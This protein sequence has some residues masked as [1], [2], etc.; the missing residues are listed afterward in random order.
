MVCRRLLRR[1]KTAR[2]MP[3]PNLNSRQ[4][5]VVNG[6]HS[7]DCIHEEANI[8]TKGCICGVGWCKPDPATCNGT[9][10]AVWYTGMPNYQPLATATQTLD[11]DIANG[12]STTQYIGY[13]VHDTD[14]RES[15]CW[16]ANHGGGVLLLSRYVPRTLTARLGISIIPL[17]DIPVLNYSGCSSGLDCGR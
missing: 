14:H 4:L 12:S 11:I 15:N 8:N 1:G 13:S 17:G 2:R 5:P 16:Y 10:V 6:P 9:M 3:S 7:L